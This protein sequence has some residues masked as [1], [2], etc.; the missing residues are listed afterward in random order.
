MTKLERIQSLLSDYRLGFM[1]V[2]AR[3]ALQN[4]E[5]RIRFGK[6][7][8]ESQTQYL[9]ETETRVHNLNPVG[10][11]MLIDGEESL[12]ITVSLPREDGDIPAYPKTDDGEEQIPEP[13]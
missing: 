12:V 10:K 3:P 7:L 13:A 6:D 2:G 11:T 8:S 4:M 1:G 9:N 5:A